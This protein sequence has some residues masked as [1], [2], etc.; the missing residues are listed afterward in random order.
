MDHIGKAE[1]LLVLVQSLANK[2]PGFFD[3]KGPGP[4]DRASNEFM[5]NLRQL[6]KKAFGSDYSEHKVRDGTKFAI[7]FYFPDERTAVEIAFGLDKPNTEFE[8]DIF[9]CLLARESGLEIERLIFMGKPG[10]INKQSGPGQM[11]IRSY[12][13]RRF[14][15]K[16]DIFEIQQ[17]VG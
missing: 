4:G 12:V 16:I 3:T 2:T 9:K 5:K 13:E 1:K 11:A 7:D 8:R 10:A 6:A 15:L 17:E 14:S